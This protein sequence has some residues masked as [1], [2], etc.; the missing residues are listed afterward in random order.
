MAR[1]SVSRRFE[2]RVAEAAIAAMGDGRALADLGEIGQQR[3]AVFSVH[4]RAYRHL[5]HSIFAVGAGAVLPHAIT[6]TPGLEVL[7]VAVVDQRVQAGDRFD[8]NVAAIAAVRAAELDELLAPERDAAV[9]AGAGLHIDLSFIE[10]FHER[11]LT[12]LA[13]L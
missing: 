3:C 13:S 11:E 4:L 6:A 9:A 7:L 2:M 8:H 5:E 12:L 1:R 10:E